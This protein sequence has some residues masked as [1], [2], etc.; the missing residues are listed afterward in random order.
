VRAVLT[1]G[2]FVGVHN[3][4]WVYRGVPILRVPGAET[5]RRSVGMGN[6]VFRLL[7]ALSDQGEATS[8]RRNLRRYRNFK[9]LVFPDDGFAA[10]GVELRGLPTRQGRGAWSSAMTSL[11][12]ELVS[13]RGSIFDYVQDY[14]L[15]DA[16]MRDAGT[17]ELKAEQRSRV[18]NWMAGTG[19]A[20]TRLLIHADHVH[21]FRTATSANIAAARDPSEC[22]NW[23]IPGSQVITMALVPELDQSWL[24]STLET[25]YWVNDI[26]ELGPKVISISGRVE[27]SSLTRI[28]KTRGK[29]KRAQARRDNLG[30][31]ISP[32]SSS[33]DAHDGPANLVDTSII[34]AIGHRED[35]VSSLI[36]TGSCHLSS[37]AFAQHAAIAETMPC[38]PVRAAPQ[39]G[40][41]RASLIASAPIILDETP[42]NA[43]PTVVN[44]PVLLRVEGHADE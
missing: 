28:E 14:T 41:Y 16:T 22:A 24:W 19:E 29:V 17:G 15:V 40:E 11:S 6:P 4:L 43:S 30:G 27:P 2:R 12:E 21:I 23:D 13:G 26:C 36:D 18:L 7:T 31:R 37:L 10:V 38:S 1:G 33:P 39:R 5:V 9:L 35:H 25:A 3:T 32:G 34:V 44:R 8:G 20:D 42:Q